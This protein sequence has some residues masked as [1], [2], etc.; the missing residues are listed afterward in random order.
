M[1]PN[2]LGVVFAPNLLRSESPDV[3][4]LS[5]S[6]EAAKVLASFIEDFPVIFS[7]RQRG[8]AHSARP[9]RG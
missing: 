3:D 6:M 1:G 7:V 8:H 2:N 9:R 4:S 5:Q